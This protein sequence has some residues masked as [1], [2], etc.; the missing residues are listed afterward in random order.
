MGLMWVRMVWPRAPHSAHLRFSFHSLGK[1]FDLYKTWFWQM[2]PARRKMTEL[3]K[4]NSK[5]T[6]NT[7]DFFARVFSYN[8]LG[9]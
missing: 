4:T 5:M 9:F 3:Q 1:G 6:K 7:F 2:P 8:F